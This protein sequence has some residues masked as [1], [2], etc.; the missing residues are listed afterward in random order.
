MMSTREHRQ[1]ELT[2]PEQIK[3]L[4]AMPHYIQSFIIEHFALTMVENRENGEQ[5]ARGVCPNCIGDISHRNGMVD[6]HLQSGS[7]NFAVRLTTTR[8]PESRL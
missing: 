1:I 5:P 4:L 8:D 3:I 7:S 2:L 6:Q